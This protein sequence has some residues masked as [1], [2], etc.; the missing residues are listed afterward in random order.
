EAFIK[1]AIKNLSEYKIIGF[2]ILAILIQILNFNIGLIA[3]K[4]NEILFFNDLF[5]SIHWKRY[6]NQR[7]ALVAAKEKTIQNKLLVN[8][9]I[10]IGRIKVDI[11]NTTLKILI[12]PNF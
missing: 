12:I 11:P 3:L 6:K 5:T 2:I 8:S 7:I 10:K 1:D 9:S 4:L